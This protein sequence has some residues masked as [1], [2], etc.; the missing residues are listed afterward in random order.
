MTTTWGPGMISSE[1]AQLVARV[2]FSPSGVTGDMETVKAEEQSLRKQV[3]GIC[4]QD[5][6]CNL[7]VRFRLRL[8]PTNDF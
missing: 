6:R 3:P 1:D 2:S 4:R 7:S 5:T 8:K